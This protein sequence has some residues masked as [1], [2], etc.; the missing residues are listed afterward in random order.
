[1]SDPLSVAG[2]AVGIISLGIQVC[3]GLISYLQSFKSQDQDIQDSLKDVQTV[4]SILYSL[5][6]ILPKVDESSS[7]TPAIRRCLAES[8]EKLREFQ[9]FSLKLRGTQSQEHNVLEKMGHA[10]RALLYPFREG[11]L[12]SLSQSLKG[13]LQ[14]L[15]LCLDITTLDIAVGIHT[16]V[17]DL[18][19][20]FKHHGANVAKLSDQL[21]VLDNSMAV[22]YQDL[23][24]EVSQAQLLAQEFRQEIGGQLRLIST[25]V[26]SLMSS[27]RRH[28]E[29]INQCLMKAFDELK[30]QNNFQ[31]ELIRTA[32]VSHIADVFYD[33]ANRILLKGMDRMSIQN[34]GLGQTTALERMRDSKQFASNPPGCTCERQHEL[35]KLSYRFGYATFEDRESSPYDQDEDGNSHALL[36]LETTLDAIS[37]LLEKRITQ[38]TLESL[39]V[40]A[41]R[42]IE[43]LV[44]TAGDENGKIKHIF[45]LNPIMQAMFQQSISMLEIALSKFPEAVRERTYGMTIVEVC[46]Y[47]P[48]GL[49]KLLRT[50]A[51]EVLDER[52]LHFAVGTDCIES[53]DLLLKA[54]CPVNYGNTTEMIFQGA[55]ERCMDLI[56]SSLARRRSDLL[57]LVLQQQAICQDLVLTSQIPDDQASYLCSC[58]DNSGIRIPLALRVPSSYSTIYHFRGTSVYHYPILFKHGFT[59]LSAHNIFGLLPVMT[60]DSFYQPRWIYSHYEKCLEGMDWLESKGIMDQSPTDPLDLGL[61]IQASGWHYLS[62]YCV[63]CE[64]SPKLRDFY[65]EKTK[66]I[67]GVP[68]LDNCRCWCIPSDMGC[69][70]L[71]TA[72]KSCVKRFNGSVQI[73]LCNFFH[74]AIRDTRS[75]GSRIAGWCIE[76]IRFLTFEALEMTHTCCDFNILYKPDILSE[77]FDVLMNC[78]QERWQKIRSDKREQENA[79]LL[80]TLMEEFIAYM[81]GMESSPRSLETFVSGY[82]R[83]RI[84]EIYAVDADEIEDINSVLVGTKT[85]VLPD[86]VRALLGWDFKLIEL[87]D[88]KSKPTPVGET[89]YDEQWQGSKQSRCVWNEYRPT[90]PD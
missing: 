70:P 19:S 58:L 21:Q 74:T 38:W 15:S 47:W 37:T 35:S 81:I 49:R 60:L 88:L 52:A 85:Y 41:K 8:E 3:Q 64:S 71:T 24:N 42:L 46:V 83:Q 6:G 23:K 87:Q 69:T 29:D 80:E 50:K 17:D 66:D 34:A 72:L 53:V 5:K 9:Q 40:S 1:M 75:S 16:N 43:T 67:L 68:V 65:H 14:N 77:K 13:L 89:A 32:L 2:S 20:A 73:V 30:D 25:D 28:Q 51:V 12:K 79:A 86:R 11:K 44:N 22:Y 82:W 90:H 84:S 57:S 45:E 7:G 54:G 55:S 61:N 26:G 10:S 4:V 39:L 33:N 27:N 59:H 36:A 56:A 62:T 48:E 63:G 76:V 18:G 31:N 78:D